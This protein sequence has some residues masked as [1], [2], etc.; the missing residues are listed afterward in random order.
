MAQLDLAPQLRI[1]LQWAE[2]ELIG[3][4]TPLA[5]SL[6]WLFMPVVV[7][8]LG[9]GPEKKKRGFWQGK[10]GVS[11]GEF[12]VFSD[13]FWASGGLIAELSVRFGAARF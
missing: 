7:M 4:G 8:V 1:L 12:R 9:S 10:G 3:N 6:V 11:G 5:L 2:L 13:L